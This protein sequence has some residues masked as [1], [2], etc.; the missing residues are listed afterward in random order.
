[1]RLIPRR[2]KDFDFI[3]RKWLWFTI[4]GIVMAVAIVALLVRGLNFGIDFTGGTEMDIRVKPGTSIQDVRA[5]T[6]S[7]GS[8]TAQIQSSGENTFIIRIPKLAG[9]QRTQLQDALKSKAGLQEVLAVNDV[10]PGWGGQVSRQALIALLVFIAAILIYISF[11]FEFKMAITAI[12]EL[13]HDT[14]ITIGIYALT[15]RQVTPATVIAVLTILGYS[16]Y[17]TIVV[18]DRIKENSDLLTRQS[19]KTYSDIANDSV[20]QVLARSINTSLTTL[21]PIVSILFFGGPTLQ[22][23]AFP[24]FIGV[25]SGAYSSIILA[26]PILSMMKEAEPKYKAYKE[27]ATRRQTRDA[28]VSVGGAAAVPMPKAAPAK[29]PAAKKAQGGTRAPQKKAQPAARPQPKPQPK[30]AAGEAESPAPKPKP[31]PKQAGGAQQTSKGAA[32]SRTKGP[33]SGKKKKR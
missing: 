28:R 16:L 13:L 8:A 5:A 17:D 1:V 24:L 20:N 18:F 31:K 29:A 4:S 19:R 30:P 10:G 21:I 2:N 9:D 11:R 3:G 15:G 12:I 33:G 22:A 6:S 14:L 23:F 25:V 32:K 26:P 27:Q 7:V